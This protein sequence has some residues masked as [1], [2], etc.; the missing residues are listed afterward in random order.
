MTVHHFLP[1]A[2][3]EKLHHIEAAQNNWRYLSFY[4]LRLEQGARYNFASEDKERALVPLN[5]Q[6][7][8]ALAQER[9]SLARQ[10]VFSEMPQVLYIPPRQAVEVNA[11]TVC[12]F[13]LGE[14]PAQGIHPP[15]LFKP[16]EMKQEVRGGGPAHRQVNH[17]LAHPLPAERL[18]LF[19][20]YVPAGAWSG[21]PPHCHDGFDGSPYLEETYFY[22][23]QPSA[24]GFG[25][26]RNY[27][28][29]EDF[30]EVFSVRHNDLVLV[31]RGFHPTVA[32]PGSAMY[33]L[34]FLAG[35]LKED[36]RAT[37]PL[38]DKDW[39]FMKK[40]RWDENRFALPIF[41]AAGKRI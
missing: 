38:D 6:F 5:G 3:S 8:V 40:N 37:P 12:E 13:A 31:T 4:A 18:I 32:A 16:T 41:D 20:V 23:F 17:I 26:H 24:T 11:K 30:N 1:Q 28:V 14:A 33:F 25:I 35:E 10:D 19:E 2:I 34:N 36:E 21:W 15:R 39:G 27:R 7:E 29:D 22:R 9:F